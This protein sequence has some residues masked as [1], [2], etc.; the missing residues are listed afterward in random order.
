MKQYNYCYL[1]L[2]NEFENGVRSLVIISQT[3]DWSD[4]LTH[5]ELS[6]NNIPEK[7]NAREGILITYKDFKILHVNAM[8]WYMHQELCWRYMQ[9]FGNYMLLFYRI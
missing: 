8:E 2:F 5:C 7:K 3:L 9:P 6:T 1:D 4:S